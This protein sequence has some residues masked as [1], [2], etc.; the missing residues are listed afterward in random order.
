[1]PEAVP[2][3]RGAAAALPAGSKVP[4]IGAPATDLSERLRLCVADAGVEIDPARGVLTGL[5]FE[6]DVVAQ[7]GAGARRRIAPLHRA[8][9]VG[10]PVPEGLA[11][12]ER[13]LEGDFL[14]APFGRDDLQ[15]GG[16]IHG[17]AANSR[18]EVLDHRETAEAALLRL[19]LQAPVRGAV[20]EKE[21]RL[22]A[23]TPF[24]FQTHR[25]HGG[26]GALSLAHHPMLRFAGGGRLCFSAKRAALTASR[27]EPG[28]RLQPAARGTDLQALPG[29]AGPLDL[30]GFP[31]WPPGHEDFLTLVEAPGA[32]LGWTAALRRAERDLVLVLKDPAR[33]PVTMLWLSN[34]GRQAAPWDG[35]H[36]GVIGIEDAC[37]AGDEG[38]RA[39]ASGANR[40]AAEGVATALPLAPGRSHVTFQAIGALPLPAGW[41]GVAEVAAG[42]GR[43]TI[44]PEGGGAALAFDWPAE[45]GWPQQEARDAG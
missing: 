31:D 41:T 43:L 7:G 16:P 25:I 19:C 4:G 5:W 27:V 22:F 44:R 29:V 33:L 40:I 28:H 11:P 32:R 2:P 39:A 10:E 13:G 36:L 30:G 37:A 38:N 8:H 17:P 23:G 18:W 34:G 42:G 1:M 20:L 9:W 26:E 24:L 35:R 14:S 3:G 21:L 12:V 45:A 6:T 15:P